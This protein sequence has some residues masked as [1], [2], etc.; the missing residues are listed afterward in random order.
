[1]KRNFTIG[2]ILSVYTGKLMCPI[3]EIYEIA[4]FL[5]QADVYTHQL[6]RVCKDAQPWLLESLPWLEGITLSEVTPENYLERLAFYAVEHGAAHELSS[7]PHAEE[8]RRDPVDEA[9]E[10][11][12]GRVLKVQ[13]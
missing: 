5:A 6:P 7:I 3:G 12:P 10:M 11:A 2:Q 1:M 4:S 9:E 13:I 8:L